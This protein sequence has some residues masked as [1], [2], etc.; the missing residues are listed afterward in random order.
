M[1]QSLI[2]YQCFRY[3]ILFIKCTCVLL[4]SKESINMYEYLPHFDPASTGHAACNVSS[5]P[6]PDGCKLYQNAALPCVD[7]GEKRCYVLFR[8]ACY[9]IN[10]N[11]YALYNFQQSGFIHIWCTTYTPNVA[12]TMTLQKLRSQ[13]VIVS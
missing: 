4:C 6:T 10:T 1:F 8:T 12:C 9:G 2:K 11:L 3:S 5:F 7:I 13:H